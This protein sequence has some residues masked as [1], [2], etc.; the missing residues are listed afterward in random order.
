MK[1]FAVVFAALLLAACQNAPIYQVTSRPVPLTAQNLSMGQIE[2]A[3]I[4]AG[5]GRGWRMERVSPGT[6]RAVQVAPKYSATIDIVYDRK[7]YSIRHVGSSGMRERDGTVH[8]HYNFWI[9]NLE[10][11]IQN[12]LSNAAILGRV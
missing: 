9:R 6:L 7:A 12:S 3:I 2:R 4:L 1:V 10:A 11:D 5:Q 8:P